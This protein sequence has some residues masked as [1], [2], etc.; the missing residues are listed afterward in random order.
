LTE[1]DLDD[2]KDIASLETDDG[3][4]VVEVHADGRTTEMSGPNDEYVNPRG[5]RF[6]PQEPIKDGMYIVYT[7]TTSCVSIFVYKLP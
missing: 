4:D 5:V 7:V 6:T 1:E 3:D 2:N